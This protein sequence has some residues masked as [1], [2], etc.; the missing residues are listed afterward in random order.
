MGSPRV[1]FMDD[2]SITDAP[3]MSLLEVEGQ[4]DPRIDEKGRFSLPAEIRT[5]LNLAEGSELI[6]TRHTEERCLILFWPEAWAAFKS[7]IAALSPVQAS[8]IRRVVQGSAR[9]LTLDKVGR[10]QIPSLLRTF[11]GIELQSTCLLNGVGHCMELWS[12]RIWSERFGGLL[13]DSGMDL[14]LQM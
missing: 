4:F 2:P 6:L 7:R 12:E 9:K 13:L 11:S 3:T 10:L 8:L 5:V 1:E 14:L